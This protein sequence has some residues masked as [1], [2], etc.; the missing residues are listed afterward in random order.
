MANPWPAQSTENPF[1]LFPE[2]AIPGHLQRRLSPLKEPRPEKTPRDA[3]TW[4]TPL[5][6]VPSLPPIP[7]NHIEKTPCFAIRPTDVRSLR[8]RPSFCTL[9]PFDFRP[10]SRLACR[11]RSF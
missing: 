11:L 8:P 1:E 3:S 9:H 2:P 4:I 10:G 6:V 7:R 5:S